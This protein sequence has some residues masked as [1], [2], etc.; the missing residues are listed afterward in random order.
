MPYIGKPQSADAFRVTP[1]NIDSELKLAVSGSNDSEMALATASIAA[2][3]ASI[4]RL[5]DEISTDDTDM[6]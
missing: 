6:T 5:N 1:N 2:I 4:S 3:T